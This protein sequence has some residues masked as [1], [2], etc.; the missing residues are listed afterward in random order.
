CQSALRT[1]VR[2]P[3][4]TA[5][6]APAASAACRRGARTIAYA[7]AQV[8]PSDGRYIRRSAMMVPMGRRKFEVSENAARKNAPQK[9]SGLDRRHAQA[10]P[11][12]TPKS[13]AAPARNPASAG[14]VTG[15]IWL[16]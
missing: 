3:Y 15:G 5:S 7:A 6:N 8:K 2:A 10:V 4:R 11:P 1:T 9:N 16:N 13:A 12:A 14:V